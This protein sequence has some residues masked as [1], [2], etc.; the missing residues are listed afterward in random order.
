MP[1]KTVLHNLASGMVLD[2]SMLILAPIADIESSIATIRA[3]NGKPLYLIDGAENFF[4]PQK[5]ISLIAEKDKRSIVVN[6]GL[7]HFFTDK[8]MAALANQYVPQ[9]VAVIKPGGAADGDLVVDLGQH[10]QHAPLADGNH[11]AGQYIYADVPDGWN[12]NTHMSL[13]PTKIKRKIKNS[14]GDGVMFYMS[15]GDY[16]KLW[17]MARNA[18]AQVEDAPLVATFMTSM[19][20]LKAT[21]QDDRISLG[22]NYVRRYEIEQVAKHRNWLLPQ[23]LAA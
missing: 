12:I 2:R 11:N 3:A 6:E 4:T 13:G 16:E 17:T 8:Q 18:W 23:L 20:K 22:G 9:N 14:D 5:L 21:I 19:G 15:P 7:D 10:Q 1:N